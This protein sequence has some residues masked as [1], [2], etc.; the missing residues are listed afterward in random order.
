MSVVVTTL[1]PMGIKGFEGR[2][3]R[4]VEGTF[5][6]L[7]RS[8]LSPVEFGRK[9]VR[10]MDAHRTVGV[11]GRTIVPNSF[12]FRIA[13]SDEEQLADAFRFLYTRAKLACELAG[14]ATTAAILGDRVH[15]EPGSTVVAV[16]SG[17]NVSP[18]TASAI[19]ARR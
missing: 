16:V 19:L 8:G 3:E 14:A 5:S 2:L 12:Q 15:L 1:G 9:L 17:G 10:E 7:F 11:D 6:R 13:A 4:A 18:E